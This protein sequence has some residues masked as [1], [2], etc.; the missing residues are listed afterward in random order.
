MEFYHRPVMLGECM[1]G[2]N[3]KEDGIYFDGTLGGAGHSFEILKRCTRGRLIA[4]DLDDEAIAAA[5]E[6]LSPYEGRFS[7]YKSNYK[8]YAQVFAAEKVEK[9]DGVLLDFGV[10]S[11][12]LD[13]VSRGFSYMAKDAALDMRMDESAPLTAEEVVNTYSVED[14][15]R[16]F[17]EYGEER[18]AFQ[19]AKNIEKARAKKPIEKSGEL[20]EIIESSIPWKFRQN[21]PCQRKVFQA[22]RIE[23][24]GELDGLKEC[25]IGL[26][27]RLKKGGR[28]AILTFH[29]L[30]DRIVKEAFREMAADCVCPPSFPVCVC[31]KQREIEIKTGKPLVA[32]EEEQGENSRSKCAKLRVAERI[33]D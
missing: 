5:R 1:E 26:T 15:T 3:I 14:L 29:S 12:Q 19:I 24:N 23:V 18:F 32:S 7:I 25:V 20:T 9:V 31:G 2:L 30:E 22:I 28:I 13:D 17:R 16:I 33:L 21:G 6:R 11:H 27:R 4:T 8:D 10:S